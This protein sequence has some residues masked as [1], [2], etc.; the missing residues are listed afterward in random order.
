MRVPIACT[1][2]VDDAETRV[3]EWRAAFVRSIASGERV[4]PTELV[5]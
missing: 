5:G 4:S 2:N 3:D 1:L